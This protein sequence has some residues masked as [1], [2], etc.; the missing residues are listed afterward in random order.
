MGYTTLN[1]WL[2]IHNIVSQAAVFAYDGNQKISYQD[3]ES[4]R[5]QVDYLM[6]CNYPKCDAEL[7]VL[8]EFGYLK[9]TEFYVI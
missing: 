5:R 8:R 4:I 2:E 1:Q 7:K 3:T 6:S 9:D